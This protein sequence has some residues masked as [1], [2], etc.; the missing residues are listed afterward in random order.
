MSTFYE[1]YVSLCAQSEKTPS[2]AAV[3]IGLSKG[4]AN[5]WKNGKRPND[6]TLAKLAAYFGVPVSYFNEETESAL[7]VDSLPPTPK[8]AADMEQLFNVAT[9]EQKIEWA[10]RLISSLSDNQQAALI[11]RIMFKK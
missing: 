3:E 4:T 8:T 5:G 1:K 6:L 9:D 11:Q 7:P 2:G 10:A